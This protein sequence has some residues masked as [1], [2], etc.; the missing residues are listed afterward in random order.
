M[1][2]IADLPATQVPFE[3]VFMNFV[4]AAKDAV[5]TVDGVNMSSYRFMEDMATNPDKYT[6]EWKQ[7]LLVGGIG[8]VG[9]TVAL[10]A[11]LLAG[12]PLTL[13]GAMVAAPFFGGNRACTIVIANALG[14]KL[15]KSEIHQNCGVQTGQ[16]VFSET[17]DETGVTLSTNPDVI[18]GFNASIPGFLMAGVGMYRFEKDLSLVIGFYGTGGAISFTAD[19]PKFPQKIAIAWLVPETGDP[20]FAVTGNLSQ[21]GS[22]QAF[23]DKT[24]GAGVNDNR[25]FVDGCAR[26]YGSLMYRRYPDEQNINDLVL[27]VYV[28]E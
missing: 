14:G 6:A 7:A 26:V 10:S 1:A 13:I 18:P 4:R 2:A 20:H 23:Y 25:S 12:G 5:C 19:T 27:T 24:A 17:N 8:G 9:S 3:D 11:V 21:Y 15:T 16:P 22:L 28:S